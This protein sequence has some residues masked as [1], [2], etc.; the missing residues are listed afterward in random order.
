ML[1]LS[2]MQWRGRV[3]CSKLVSPLFFKASPF[4]GTV[5]ILARVFSMLFWWFPRG[6]FSLSSL[7]SK[8]SAIS[9]V[10]RAGV[11]SRCFFLE[12]R[13]KCF[14]S[15]GVSVS[16]FSFARRLPNRVCSPFVISAPEKIYPLW[17]PAQIATR[18]HLSSRNRK[19]F[20]CRRCPRDVR[21]L[22]AS[23]TVQIGL[24][25]CTSRI[26][27]RFMACAPRFFRQVDERTVVS[28]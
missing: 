11:F 17:A 4:A 26:F 24:S 9:E 5:A 15:T 12:S 6:G 13:F 7:F 16:T 25:Q 28:C 18:I 27:S 8:L 20:E 21:S 1:G 19:N 22:K 23:S 3:S 14:C 2:A 10:W